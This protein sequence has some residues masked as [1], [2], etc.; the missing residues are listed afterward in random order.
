MSSAQ[1]SAN[2]EVADTCGWRPDSPEQMSD[3]IDERCAGTYRSP[4][5]DEVYSCRGTSPEPTACDIEEQCDE[6]HIP[7]RNLLERCNS[8]I[9]DELEQLCLHDKQ[10]QQIHRFGNIP[11]IGN[12]PKSAPKIHQIFIP[13]HEGPSHLNHTQLRCAEHELPPKV[14]HGSGIKLP[15]VKHEQDEERPSSAKFHKTLQHTISAILDRLMTPTPPPVGGDRAKSNLAPKDT[16][17]TVIV[18][19][20]PSPRPKEDLSQFHKSLHDTAKDILEKMRATTTTPVK[21]D[22]SKFDKTV[23]DTIGSSLIKLRSPTPP[24]PN[25]DLDGFHSTSQ[26]TANVILKRL[27]SPSPN[28]LKE[29]LD[30]FHKKLHDTISID[31]ERLRS[32]GL[33]HHKDL[34]KFDRSLRDT[35]NAILKRLRI[36]TPA[37]AKEDPGTSGPQPQPGPKSTPAVPILGKSPKI[38][39][40]KKGDTTNRGKEKNQRAMAKEAK[41]RA[42]RERKVSRQ[43]E[44]E[45]IKQE[46]NESRHAKHQARRE[47]RHK[48]HEAERQKPKDPT[49]KTVKKGKEPEATVHATPERGASPVRCEVCQKNERTKSQAVKDAMGGS[50]SLS[51]LTN[52]VKK[53][54]VRKNMKATKEEEMVAS[55]PVQNMTFPDAIEDVVHEVVQSIMELVDMSNLQHSPMAG[56]E[57][58]STA[59]SGHSNGKLPVDG[60]DRTGGELY[61]YGSATHGLDGN[62]SPVPAGGSQVIRS[63]S[64]NDYF[65]DARAVRSASVGAQPYPVIG[66]PIERAMSPWNQRLGLRTPSPYSSHIRS[67]MRGYQ[68]DLTNSFVSGNPLL[69]RCRFFDQSPIRSRPLTPSPF[70]WGYTREDAAYHNHYCVSV[71][72]MISSLCLETRCPYDPPAPAPAPVPTG[73]FYGSSGM[74]YDGLAA[75]AA[76]TAGLSRTPFARVMPPGS[77]ETMRSSLV[78]VTPSPNSSTYSPNRFLDF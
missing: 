13:T 14:N 67:P 3:D 45:R 28:H 57:H 4:V 32:H 44:K 18:K 11:S 23:N 69:L 64:P 71:M 12:Q 56:D 36:P 17:S 21:E 39:H 33:H 74:E 61:K 54:V 10:V 49:R 22:L 68:G 26:Y 65:L 58:H 19:S 46:K 42:K 47:A 60:L 51:E 20:R 27:R 43:E 30:K 53:T 48:R 66:S 31:L 38:P 2:P 50:L 63:L 52:A 5:P 77:A 34:S 1:R 35:A 75:M 78:S 62:S 24:H 6:P 25:E 15:D 7:A 55:K 40:Q 37:S 59:D 73:P 70:S 29:D 72:P 76:A 9:E 41:A 8:E 16:T